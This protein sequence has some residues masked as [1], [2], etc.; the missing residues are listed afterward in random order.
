VVMVY[1]EALKLER[2][3]SKALLGMDGPRK[4]F[5]TKAENGQVAGSIFESCCCAL[6]AHPRRTC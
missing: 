4:S 5:L 1:A 2:K 6:K 3:V